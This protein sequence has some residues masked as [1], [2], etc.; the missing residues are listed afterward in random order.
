MKVLM[1]YLLVLAVSAKVQETWV[2]YTTNLTC[3][4]YVQNR[5]TPSNAYDQL[6]WSFVYGFMTAYNYYG[7]T[8]QFKGEL[9]PNTILAYMDKYCRDWPLGSVATGTQDLIRTYTK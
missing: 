5:R 7:T 6:V 9:K 3:G 2:G 1:I 4:D 8:P